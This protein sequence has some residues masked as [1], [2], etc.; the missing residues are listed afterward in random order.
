MPKY[1]III[2]LVK[3]NCVQFNRSKIKDF[4]SID[5]FIVLYNARFVSNFSE[6]F[7]TESYTFYNERYIVKSQS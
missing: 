4:V 2:E 6:I 5:S 3:I 1:E 7:V